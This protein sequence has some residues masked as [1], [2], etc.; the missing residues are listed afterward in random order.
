[1]TNALEQ[2]GT[3][4]QALTEQLASAAPQQ[5]AAAEAALVRLADAGDLDACEALASAYSTG[6]PALA[7][8]A[9]KEYRYTARAAELGSSFHR[10]WLAHLQ[11]QAKD[12]TSAYANASLAHQENIGPAT[13]LL[14]RMLLQGQGCS[15]QPLAALDMLT[16]SVESGSNPDAALT[17]ATLYL[18]GEHVGPHPQA[19]YDTLH[20]LASD[21][22]VI[23][24]IDKPAYA[25]YCYLKA[26]ALRGGAQGQDGETWLPLCEKA[27]SLGHADAKASLAAQ[28]RQD[29]GLQREAQWE[30]LQHFTAFSGRWM[31][32]YRVARLAEKHEKSHQHVGSINGNVYTT[33]SRWNVLVFADRD[34]SRFEVK[35]PP[36]ARVVPQRDYAVL[37]IGP[38]TGTVGVPRLIHDLG[39]GESVEP[40]G[41]LA[42]GYSEESSK[43]LKVFSVLAWFGVVVALGVSFGKSSGLALLAALGLGVAAVKLRSA[44]TGQHDEALE[45]ARA[46]FKEHAKDLAR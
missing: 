20:G 21:F 3:G 15:A 4:V 16:R 18:E 12:Y 28:H 2:A 42:S 38:A 1:M 43:A 9:I 8:N 10:Y 35:V 34:G 41:D 17:L 40:T 7:R 31:M 22:A 36:K 23:A 45:R 11:Y 25:R 44:Y 46:F 24:H 13:D 29:A 5:A 26:W 6:R 33:T 30:G 37:F 14:A 27:A 32:F 39:T 19:A